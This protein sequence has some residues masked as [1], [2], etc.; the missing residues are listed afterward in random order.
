MPGIETQIVDATARVVLPPGFA[1]STVTIQKI[2][3]NE[4]RIRKKTGDAEEDVVFPEESMTVLSDRD[5]D[6]FLELLE[7]PPP[8]TPALIDALTKRIKQDG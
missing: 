1:E 3:E 2:S 6:R 4:V 5:R 7:N 8:P